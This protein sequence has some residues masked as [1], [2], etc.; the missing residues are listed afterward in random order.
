MTTL[1]NEH[2]AT[3]LPCSNLRLITP[4]G[5]NISESNISLKTTLQINLEPIVLSLPKQEN[6]NENRHSKI[7][8]IDD[9]GP[10]LIDFL[11]EIK[12]IRSNTDKFGELIEEVKRIH[13]KMFEPM[14]NPKLE[15]ELENKKEEINKLSSEISTKLNKMV[16]AN[17]NRDDNAK[18]NAQW[19]VEELQIFDLT[20]HFRNT[21]IAYNEETVAH[22]D[23]CKKIILRTLEI[24]KL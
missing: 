10:T 1:I 13:A 7:S 5:F 23:R 4:T 19:R 8:N 15:Q 20:S 21:M 18:S 17:Q 24:C 22:H 14:A 2:R 6:Q 11:H 16:Q 12:L 9:N 3:L